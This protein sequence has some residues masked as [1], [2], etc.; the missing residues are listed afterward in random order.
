MLSAMIRS[1]S[2]GVQR[3][4]APRLASLKARYLRNSHMTSH[5]TMSPPPTSSRKAA[6]GEW[7]HGGVFVIG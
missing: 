5:T 2:S 6:L 7:I 3:P 1:F 4:R